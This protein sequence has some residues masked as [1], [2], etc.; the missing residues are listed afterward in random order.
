MNILPDGTGWI[1]P[2]R[3][4]AR[5]TMGVLWRY[6]VEKLSYHD[7]VPNPDC[8]RIIMNI[9][10]PFTRIRSWLRLWNTTLQEPIDSKT[11]IE[12]LHSGSHGVQWVNII[13]NP[14]S[15]YHPWKYV[16]PMSEYLRVL[17]E[18]N[19]SP[20][21]YIRQEFLEEDMEAAGYPTMGYDYANEPPPDM[22]EVKGNLQ[23]RAQPKGTVW[24]PSDGMSDF[25]FYE[26]NPH[27][28]DIIATYYADDF[29]NFG[30]E[31][32][33]SKVRG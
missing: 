32:D 19:Q 2:P 23:F 5:Y 21:F 33:F 8:K 31:L 1:L 14:N 26:E 10:N 11:F 6:G 16:V 29:K 15:I 27:C 3:C 4:A 22:G 30:Y 13:D 28:A 24:E 7:L 20:D 18:H 12:N 9:R 17:K 25:E